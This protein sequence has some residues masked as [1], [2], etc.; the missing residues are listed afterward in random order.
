MALLVFLCH[1]FWGAPDK[2]QVLKVNSLQLT[3][4]DLKNSQQDVITLLI[5]HFLEGLK[6]MLS[7]KMTDII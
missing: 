5:Y 6:Q 7:L 3:L 2:I 4:F 1:L